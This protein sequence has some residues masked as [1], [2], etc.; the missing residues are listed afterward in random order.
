MKITSTD[1]REMILSEVYALQT[2]SD[3]DLQ[4]SMLGKGIILRG[5]L[6][7]CRH[8]INNCDINILCIAIDIHRPMFCFT[9]GWASVKFEAGI[10]QLQAFNKATYV[11]LPII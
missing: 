1:D 2:T 8:N 5:L 4:V 7:D 11:P 6:L 10:L 9:I 3:V